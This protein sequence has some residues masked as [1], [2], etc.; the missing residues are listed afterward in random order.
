MRVLVSQ[1]YTAILHYPFGARGQLDA[2]S[3]ARLAAFVRRCG[4]EPPPLLVPARCRLVGQ[5][6]CSA[7]LSARSTIIAPTTSTDGND[8]GGGVYAG[9][10]IEP[11]KQFN[12]RYFEEIEMRTLRHETLTE[13]HE[14]ARLDFGEV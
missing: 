5:L 3:L 12:V 4:R 1:R 8:G 2:E 9:V 14:L 7:D 11:M 6:V 10:N 13:R